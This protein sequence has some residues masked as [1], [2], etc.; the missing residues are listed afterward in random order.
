MKLIL[1]TICSDLVRLFGDCRECR[2]GASWGRYVD[3]VQA[4]IGGKAIGVA[5]GNESFHRAFA[6]RE[7]EWPR[8]GRQFVGWFMVPDEPHVT[9]VK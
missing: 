3:N 4:E 9:R 6:R 8:E 5:I 1:C 2:C 7:A